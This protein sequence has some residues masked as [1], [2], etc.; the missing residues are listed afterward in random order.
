MRGSVT[1]ELLLSADFKTTGEF[2]FAPVCLA[3]VF[4]ENCCA[5]IVS[6]EAIVSTRAGVSSIIGITKLPAFAV[7]VTVLAGA[8]VAC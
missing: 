7:G 2:L 6:G 4:W 5:T 3:T 1:E 8:A